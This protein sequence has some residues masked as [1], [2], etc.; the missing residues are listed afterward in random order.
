MDINIFLVCYNESSLIPHMV[1]HYKKYLPSCNI[2][3]YDN[4]STDNSVEIAT[5]LGCKCISFDSNNSMNEYVLGDIRNNCWK[6]IKSGWIIMADMDEFICVT[7]QE[8]LDEMKKGTTILRID[9][10]NMIGESNT[11]DLTDIDLQ[12][13]K[14]Y[15]DHHPESK[16]LC[17]LRDKINNMNY[18]LGAH[19]CRPEGVIVYSSKVYIN[20]HMCC[21]G[22]KWLIERQQERYSRNAEM[23]KKNSN[24]HYINDE[25]RIIRLY[26]ES[27]QTAKTFL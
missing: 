2:T 26:N 6:V 10:K 4:Q 25:N 9:G 21:L 3:I 22:L 8:L 13:I 14:K 18:D 24:T 17:F 11:I 16:N 27:L 19:H 7:E 20:K 15:K 1:K 5:S 23:R 12:E